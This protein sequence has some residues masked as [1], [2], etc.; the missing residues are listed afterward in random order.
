[1][2]RR[3]SPRHNPSVPDRLCRGLLPGA[4]LRAAF[5]RVG[6]T[7]RAARALHGLS[8][9]TSHL[10]AEAL[11]AAA[12]FGAAQDEGGRVNL[13]V[14]CDGPLRGLLVDSD[15]GGGLRGWVK[16]PWVHFAG[17]AAEA[18]R[19][20]LGGKG[21]LSVQ[22][23]RGDG[24]FER[25]TR[26]LRDLSLPSDLRAWFAQSQ[27]VAAAVD[28]AVVPRAGEPLGEVGGILVQQE[29]GSAEEA[30]EAIRAARDRAADGTLARA[31]EAGCSAQ[32][33]IA[34]VAGPGFE[35]QADLELAYRCG[36]SAARARVAVSALGREGIAE[37]LAREGQAA[38]TCEFCRQRY[39]LGAAEL[40]E[41]ARALDGPGAG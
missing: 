29:A 12:L 31:L 33:A 19:A 2:A 34:R 5:V 22:R 16:V 37:V 24:R 38:V 21:L 17:P 18:T 9:T 1:V 23:D 28:V 40:A 15:P 35:V 26:E 7:A 20:A 10:L 39:V 27:L 3:R 41:L 4:G 11:A 30:G 36:C 14:A 32:E 6:E 8:P 13:Q 25:S